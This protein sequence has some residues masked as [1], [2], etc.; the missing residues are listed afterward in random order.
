MKK[1]VTSLAATLLVCS[2]LQAQ[3]AKAPASLRNSVRTEASVDLRQNAPDRKAARSQRVA[4]AKAHAPLPRKVTPP[5]SDLKIIDETPE[6]TN[7]LYKKTGVAY[8]YSWLTGMIYQ[9]LDG[10]TSNV[11]IS[12]DRTH[13][14]MQGP[15]FFDVYTEE[16]WIEGTL[17]GDVVTFTFPQLIDYDVYYADDEETEIEEEYFYYAMKLEYVPDEEDPDYGWYYPC[18]NQE[19]KMTLGEDGSLTPLEPETMIGSCRWYGENDIEEGEE[20]HYS[21]QANGD[22]ITGMQVVTEKVHEVPEDVEFTE[23]QLISGISNRSVYV[24]V[25]GDD[26]YIKGLYN[27]MKNA[28]V[29]GKI[30]GDKVTFGNGQY[31][32][33][34][35]SNRTLAFFDTGVIVQEG[36]GTYFD[37][38]PDMVFSYDKQKSIL[39]SEG[40]Y[41]ISTSP[42]TVLYYA[43]VD[44]PYLCIPATDFTVTSLYT[45]VLSSFYDADEEY[46]YDAEMYFNIATVD[47]EYN[48]LP[49]D[50]L[51]YEVIMDDEVFTFYSDE[52]ELPEGV[53]ETTEIPYGYYSEETYDFDAYGNQHGFVFHTRGFENL[54]VRVVYKAPDAEPIYSAILWAPGYE[55]T[56]A[57]N[58]IA[59]EAAVKEV[60]YYD[61]NGLRVLR[62]ASGVFVKKTI[63][64][65]G[66]VRTSKALVR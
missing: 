10:A 15:I 31:L 60:Q 17:E 29:T 41:C 62:P 34:Y 42:T 50:R 19:Y 26:M 1:I 57:V 55:G 20:P 64:S 9:S 54:G 36:E 13:V 12:D 58:G 47:P 8:G 48:V 25:K 14:Y 35:T 33:E 30:D 32:G 16:N 61:L 5:S 40:A 11:V 22:I 21:W 49:T 38:Q 63:L 4:A 37:I 39:T 45:P 24:G 28:V 51:F 18:E 43:I 2:G 66:T 7:T 65:D 46:D 44:K 59:A 27:S 3:K 52:Y 6:G 23:W 53:T 56:L